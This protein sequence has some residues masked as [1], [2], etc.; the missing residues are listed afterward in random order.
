MLPRLVCLVTE[1]KVTDARMPAR[2]NV[3]FAPGIIGIIFEQCKS[4]LI[5]HQVH[6]RF[7]KRRVGT[8]ILYCTAYEVPPSGARHKSC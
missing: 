7:S 2:L 1:Q 5:L 6:Y 8:R 4:D 3:Q